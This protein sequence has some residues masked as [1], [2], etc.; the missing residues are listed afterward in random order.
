[1]LEKLSLIVLLRLTTIQRNSIY[2]CWEYGSDITEQIPVLPNIKY[3][4][5]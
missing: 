5:D 4:E 3:W 1:M 2:T